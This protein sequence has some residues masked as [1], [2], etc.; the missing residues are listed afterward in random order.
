MSDLNTLSN[1]KEFGGHTI[2]LNPEWFFVVNGPEF[3]GLEMRKHMFLSL[4][5]AKEAIAKTIREKE[6]LEAAKIRLYLEV[7]DEHG[8]LHVVERINR[9]NGIM[10]GLEDAPSFGR[11]AK[12]YPDVPW[13]REAV[14]RLAA[15]NNE[16]SELMKRLND[17]DIDVNSRGLYG[18]GRMDADDVI[19]YTKRLQDDYDK[20][21]QKAIEMGTPKLTEIENKT[22]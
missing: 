20:K 18:S 15:L 11:S 22:A 5:D 16:R 7:V 8:A 10:A 9:R 14:K 1:V 21:K 17:L 12:V 3:D 13:L 4:A 2:E 19:R 6:K